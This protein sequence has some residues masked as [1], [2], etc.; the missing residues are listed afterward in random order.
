MGII[1]M[2][3][4]ERPDFLSNCTKRVTLSSGIP[5]ELENLNLT[6]GGLKFLM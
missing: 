5:S 4:S 2:F 3:T 1:I 6:S